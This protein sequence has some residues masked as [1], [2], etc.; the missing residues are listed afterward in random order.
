MGTRS[1]TLI[2]NEDGQVICFIYRQMDGYP[3]GHGVDLAKACNVPI[4]NGLSGPEDVANG[5][6]CLAARIVA[7]LKTGPGG[8][9][10]HSPDTPPDEQFIYEVRGA[11]GSLP[12]IKCLSGDT[13]V[14]DLPAD[15]AITFCENYTGD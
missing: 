10:L 1:E 13:V 4:V 7:K 14:F 15:K 6:G 3:E 2:F 11:V 12:T 8:I 5:I 9:Y